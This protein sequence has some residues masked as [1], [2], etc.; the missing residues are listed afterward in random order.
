MTK[1]MV[2]ELFGHIIAKLN[3]LFG[4]FTRKINHIQMIY[5]QRKRSNPNFEG[6][7]LVC[8]GSFE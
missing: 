2:G 4:Y 6:T 7:Y 3:T 5:V 8:K 1:I